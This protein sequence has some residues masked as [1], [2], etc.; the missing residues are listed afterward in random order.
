MKKN[1]PT[2]LRKPCLPVGHKPTT[3]RRT[4][5]MLNRNGLHA[6]PCALLI[7]A[8]LKFKCAVDVEHDG[9]VTAGRSI[10]GLMC[11][12]VGYES[13]VTFI[14]NG[15]DAPQAM[16]AVQQLFDTQFEEAYMPG[17]NLVVE[18]W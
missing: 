13:K 5:I 17:N 3:L 4:F 6:R 7:N 14:M 12:A 2:E 1:Q 10:M 18:R 16:A 8:L 11:L 9:A 15:N